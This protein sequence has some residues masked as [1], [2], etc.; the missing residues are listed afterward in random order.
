MAACCSKVFYTLGRKH[1]LACKNHESRQPKTTKPKLPAGRA[2]NAG[3]FKSLTDALK[4]AY[5]KET[6]EE[7]FAPGIIM[8][9]TQYDKYMEHAA[10]VVT[11]A[12][13]IEL[14]SVPPS[15]SAAAG[16][17]ILEEQARLRAGRSKFAPDLKTAEE[18]ALERSQEK[19]Y[20]TYTY[21]LYGN[22]NMPI[23]F[24]PSTHA[25]IRDLR[26]PEMMTDEDKAGLDKILAGA[27]AFPEG[28]KIAID[29]EAATPGHA[30]PA[31]TPVMTKTA[32]VILEEAEKKLKRKRQVRSPDPEHLREIDE[33]GA[34]K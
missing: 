5:S 14:N 2:L 20:K 6:L 11:G 32:E 24:H 17:K 33:G 28:T 8:G 22:E 7:T 27:A 15:V 16:L 9:K 12:T 4:I 21:N 3:D 34:N 31:V 19:Y 25:V 23:T 18:L 29:I 1:D 26:D 13:E 30:D 10:G